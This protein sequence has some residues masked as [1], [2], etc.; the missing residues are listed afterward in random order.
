MLVHASAI[1]C[2]LVKAAGMSMPARPGITKLLECGT[3]E[4]GVD[5]DAA[6]SDNVKMLRD[7]GTNGG[8]V[9][10][11]SPGNASLPRKQCWG[12][13]GT[14]K[15]APAPGFVW[16]RAGERSAAEGGWGGL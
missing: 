3:T 11:V 1:L 12:A 9:C 10:E 5:A 2:A 4:A 7:R 16:S 8:S 15:R 13:Y 14:Q 6:A